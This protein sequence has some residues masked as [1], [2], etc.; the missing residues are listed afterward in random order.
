MKRTITITNKT[1]QAYEI[2]KDYYSGVLSVNDFV[3]WYEKFTAEDN[4]E[5]PKLNYEEIV[6]TLL[7][8]DDI[9]TYQIKSD[10]IYRVEY[11]IGTTFEIKLKEG[12]FSHTLFCGDVD[13]APINKDRIAAV[14]YVIARGHNQNISKVVLHFA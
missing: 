4:Y 11:I 10:N 2:K 3:T 9:F 5:W 6:S 14:A 12:H 13:D 7:F 1:N 8:F